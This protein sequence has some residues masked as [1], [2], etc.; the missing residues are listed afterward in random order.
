VYLGVVAATV[1]SVL[2]GVS[3]LIV[4][5]KLQS[6]VEEIFEGVAALT[7]TAVL[8]CMIFW[9]AKSAKRI[10]SAVEE[11]IDFAVS[12]GQVFG[13][14]VLSFV[15]VFR[16]GV[17]TVLFLTTLAFTDVGATVAGLVA[18][19]V[20]ILVLA[21][22]LYRSIYR[23]N[24]QSVFRYSSVLLIVF[25]AGLAGFGVHELL[26]TGEAFGLEFG[27]WGQHAFDVNPPLED[28]FLLLC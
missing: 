27:V 6:P 28:Q 5:G 26:E 22:V 14:F 15:A 8:S 19:C 13:I 10:R 23:L 20:I 25:A 18:G 21:F 3:I 2:L 7:A 11:K 16:E 17:E 1:L 12:T 24:I 4:Y 9:M